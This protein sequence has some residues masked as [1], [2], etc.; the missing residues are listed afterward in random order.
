MNAWRVVHFLKEDTVEAVPVSWLRGSNQCHWPPFNRLK[1]KTAINKCMPPSSNWD[2][3][4]TRVIGEIY[5]DLSVARMKAL[6]AESTSDLNSDSDLLGLGHRKIRMNKKYQDSESSEQDK[7]DSLS[8]EASKIMMPTLK[9]RE[10]KTSVAP[11]D[12]DLGFE[13]Y[14]G[15]DNAGEA[16]KIVMSTLKRRDKESAVYPYSDDDLGIESNV[17][18]F[19]NAGNPLRIV[20]GNPDRNEAECTAT[21]IEGSYYNRQYYLKDE[22]FKRQVL[23]NLSILNFKLDQLADDIGRLALKEN[24][25]TTNLPPSV[26]SK[27]NFPLATEEE[28]H[29]FESHL[30]DREKYQQ[31]QL[32]LSRIGGGTTKIMVRRLMEKL[33]SSQLGVEYSW[34]GFKKKKNFSVLLISKVLIDAVLAVHKNSNAA[35]VEASAKQ[36]LVKCKERCTKE[37]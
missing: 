34:I 31:V 37:K 28:L 23:R 21:E 17:P 16:S 15:S 3:H 26:F 2:V 29:N 36:W 12:D 32:E 35:E 14:V 25:V 18:G 22:Q 5:G 7:E 30:A 6:E 1:L 4:E 13:S 8:P 24:T 19:D 20:P 10:E 11:S 9:R 27:F 33:I